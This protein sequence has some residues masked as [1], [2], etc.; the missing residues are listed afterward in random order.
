MDAENG[1]LRTSISAR[2]EDTERQSEGSFDAQAEGAIHTKPESELWTQ[3]DGDIKKKKKTR[4]DHKA[5]PGG[6]FEWRMQK[7]GN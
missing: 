1:I 4:R 7:S 6:L 5:P 2:R 3:V